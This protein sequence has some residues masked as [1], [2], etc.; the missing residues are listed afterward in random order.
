LY[1]SNKFFKIVLYDFRQG[2]IAKK[3]SFVNTY[4][5]ISRTTIQKMWKCM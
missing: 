2:F 1:F 4:C 3:Q 5:L